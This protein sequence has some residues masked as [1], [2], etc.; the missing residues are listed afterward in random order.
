MVG[1][2][3]CGAAA[4]GIPPAGPVTAT[5]TAANLCELYMSD[6]RLRVLGPDIGALG[7]LATLDISRNEL[8]DLP[9]ELGY[10]P[11]LQRL[12]VDGNPMR[13]IRRTLV[14]GPTSA[15]K[16]YLRTRGPPHPGL[17]GAVEDRDETTDDAGVHA[18]P[19]AAQ[20]SAATEAIVTI[21]A[22]TAAPSTSPPMSEVV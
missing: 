14:E 2:R 20:I 8:P 7:A 19:A 3:P 11:K 16:T 9:A 17:T 10:L 1:H 18:A 6:N 22:N 13:R 15:L 12:L 4:H 21:T 5:L